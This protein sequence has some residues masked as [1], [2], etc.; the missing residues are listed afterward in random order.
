[1]TYQ[2]NLNILIIYGGRTNSQLVPQHCFDDLC[3]LNIDRLFWARVRV[4]GAAAPRRAAHAAGFF[5]T[6]F[7]VF[8]GSNSASFC[9]SETY[10]YELDQ[11]AAKIQIDAD[12]K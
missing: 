12:E 2:V 4:H 5:D 11:V 6:Q 9:S 8:G 3:V 10:I 1:M 7:V